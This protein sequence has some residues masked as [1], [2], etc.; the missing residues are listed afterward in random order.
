MSAARS[1]TRADYQGSCKY[2]GRK[3]AKWFEKQEI[4]VGTPYVG[5]MI[6]IRREYPYHGIEQIVLWDDQSYHRLK[7]GSGL[8][9]R[10]LCAEYFA[11]LA[12]E[13]GYRLK[14]KEPSQ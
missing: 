2:C 9:C 12:Y 3:A 14:Q 4:A 8:F 1:F 13:V 10:L 6:E 5:N 7:Y 11:E